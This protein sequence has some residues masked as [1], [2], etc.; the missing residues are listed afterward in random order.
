[1]L[2]V[3]ESYLGAFAVELGHREAALA[4]LA[5]L[6]PL[7]GALCQLA[8]P[9]LVGLLGNRK[10]LVVLGAA[11]QGFAH[12]GFM[13]I[14]RAEDRSLSL[15][16]LA[17][18]AFWTSGMVIAPPWNAWMGTLTE[19]VSR[20]RYFLWRTVA[21][22][23]AL[24]VSF[25]WAGYFLQAGRS[26]GVHQHFAVIFLVGSIARLLA[27]FALSRHTDPEPPAS[28]GTPLARR[29]RRALE[30]GPWKLAWAIG[31][32]Q[33]GAHI[34][35][36]FFTPYMLRELRLELD[37]FAWLSA[38][39]IVAKALTLPIWAGLAR[40]MGLGFCMAASVGT[41]ATVPAIWAVA[42]GL[43]DLIFVQAV[44][45]L[46]WAGFEYVS[47]QLLLGSAPKSSSVE[48]FSLSS[49]LTGALQL[50]G[51]LTGSALLTSGTSYETV[52]LLSS[53][54]RAL[55][56]LLLTPVATTLGQGLR[57]RRIWLRL[58]SVRPSTGPER[59]P[60][61]SEWDDGPEQ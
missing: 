49:S 58:V 24:L 15:L 8:A 55:P 27:A 20:A 2:G 6:P 42:R 45:G 46:G 12:I 43:P 53:A 10:R 35:V 34:S 31:L 19:G 32:L 57:L 60:V 39:T 9:W 48:F 17:K 18:I 23:V 28:T 61:A 21:C 54:L 52:F 4:L 50:A 30:A 56:L 47:L 5:T 1:M 13:A 29:L 44:G 11:L 40:R 41:I 36:P 22:H 37:T 3:S 14:A 25:L 38:I 33:F 26:S 16:L 59:R 51:S 7:C